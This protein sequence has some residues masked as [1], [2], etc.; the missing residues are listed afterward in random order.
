[1]IDS[2]VLAGRQVELI[3]GEI[4]DMAPESPLHA[5]RA[6]SLA[7]Y[8]R[9][10]LAGRA[11][12]RESYPVTLLSD[13]EPAPDIAVVR[14]RADAYARTHPQPEDIF[15]LLEI[16][17]STVDYDLSTKANLYAR[18]GIA[19]YWVVDLPADRVGVHRQPREGT[20]QSVN[21][22]QSGTI[23]PLAFPDIAVPLERLLG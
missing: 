7:E 2:G 13:S 14:W 10:Q 1:M 23:A 19:D 20:Y 15:W 17:N 5:S 21:L 9:Q 6:W 11:V 16:S 3:A 8:L 22:V 4:V 18:A 12:I